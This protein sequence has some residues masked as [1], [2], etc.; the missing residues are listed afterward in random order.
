MI[1]GS[2]AVIGLIVSML[3]AGRIAEGRGRSVRAWIWLAAVF[4]P[5]ATMAAWVLPAK[6]APSHANGH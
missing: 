1:E 5:F 2:I 4:G 6:R 3:L